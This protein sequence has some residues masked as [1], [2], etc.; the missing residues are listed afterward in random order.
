[1][2]CLVYLAVCGDRPNALLFY[3]IL[4]A[5]PT[6]YQLQSQIYGNN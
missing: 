3:M 4:R 6:E 2:M 5:T 1:M